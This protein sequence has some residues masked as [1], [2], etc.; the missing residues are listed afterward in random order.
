MTDKLAFAINT[1]L[2]GYYEEMDSDDMDA[3]ARMLEGTN[4]KLTCSEHTNCAYVVPRFHAVRNTKIKD[5]VQ[6]LRYIEH[7]G[8]ERSAEISAHVRSILML[9]DYELHDVDD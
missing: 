3:I 2:E 1:V 7:N 6:E 5:A 8:D 9:L 4:W